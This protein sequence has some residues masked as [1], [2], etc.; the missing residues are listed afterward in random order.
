MT[1]FN[2]EEFKNKKI[3]IKCDTLEKAKEFLKLCKEKGMTWSSGGSLENSLW[4]IYKNK[5][6]YVYDVELNGLMYCHQEFY[7]TEG[8]KIVQWEK[9][10]QQK[11]TIGYLLRRIQE[12]MNIEKI[13]FIKAEGIVVTTD[14]KI[15]QGI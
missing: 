5:T 8:Y 3:A 10:P 2:I 4:E 14:T 11:E 1:T 12:E 9:E 7:T 15:I 13:N 6:C